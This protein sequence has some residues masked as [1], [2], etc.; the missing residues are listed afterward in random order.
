VG[1]SRRLGRR[2]PHLSGKARWAALLACGLL[3][4]C[5]SCGGQ[6]PGT[7]VFFLGNSFTSHNGGLGAQLAAMAPGCRAQI[8]APGG[9]TLQEHWND[10]GETATIRTGHFDFVVLQE[11][12]QTPVYDRALFASYAGDLA[13]LIKAS[14]AK[15]ILLMTWQRPDSV[16]WG[17]TTANLAAA[18]QS[19]GA[20]I[21][22]KVVP[23]GL[24]FCN[25]QTLRPD[26]ALNVSD[27][28]PTLAGTYLAACV[29][30]GTIFNRS[31]MDISH[32][33]PG[34]SP[35]DGAFLKQVAAQ[36]LGY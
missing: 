19:V 29:V 31:P 8:Y 36:T 14:G 3:V 23:A 20:A 10:P 15:P 17:V 27:G 18:Y 30:Y 21:G 25:A 24:A 9:F 32:T 4:L 1:C 26:I 12:S 34:I 2:S 11:Q 6:Q 35:E 22:A 5:G 28:H 33:P 7:K 13:R 16:Q